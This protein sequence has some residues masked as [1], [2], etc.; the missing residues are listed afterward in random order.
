MAREADAAEWIEAYLEWSEIQADVAPPNLGAEI[1]REAVLLMALRAS[2]TLE[3]LA[4]D[5][6]ALSGQARSTLAR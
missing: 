6:R 3:A 5:M 4:A 1:S 2:E